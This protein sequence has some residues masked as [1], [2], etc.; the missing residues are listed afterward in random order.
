MSREKNQKTKSKVIISIVAYVAVFTAV[1]LLIQAFCFS[2]MRVEGN[3]M[4]PA[5]V[6]HDILLVDKLAYREQQPKRYDLM[7][8]KYKYDVSTKYI[9]RVIGLP[10]ETVEI[11][12]NKIFINGSELQEYYGLY[13]DDEKNLPDYPLYQLKSD[14]YFVIGDNREHSVDSRSG[15][16][17][18]VTKDMIVGKAVFR[19]W[20]FQA[21]GSLKNQ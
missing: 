14:E 5:L 9:K 11:K 17:G 20:P 12:E 2:P 6:D 15:D 19:L 18:P 4:N 8:F 3:S 1:V 21:A 13:D 16:V 7:V 10:G